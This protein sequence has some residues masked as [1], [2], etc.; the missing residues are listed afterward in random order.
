MAAK[1]KKPVDEV[2]TKVTLEPEPTKS[3]SIV[4]KMAERHGMERD[5]F[6]RVLNA[7]VMPKSAKPEQAAA[8]LMICEK[9]DLDPFASEVY[10][11]P[12]QGGVKA[13]VGVDGFIS[14]ANRNPAFDGLSYEHAFNEAGD[15]TAI[16]CTVHR[17]DRAQPTSATEYMAECVGRS[18]IWKTMPNR[19]LR[20]K[21]T[22]QAIRLAF[23]MA[24]LGDVDEYREVQNDVEGDAPDLNA[25][26][27]KGEGE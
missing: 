18:P 2:L 7:T 26:V 25:I 8:F 23:G 4:D 15:I 5:T 6:L 12:G 1:K 22:I 21:A 14:I 19:M 9:Y 27:T 10:A 17:K 11:F 3:L 16:T 24:G 13:L 20:H